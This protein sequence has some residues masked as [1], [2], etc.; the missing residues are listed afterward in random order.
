MN[1]SVFGKCMEDVRKRKDIRLCCSSKQAEKLIAKPNFKERTI[2]NS[3]LAAVHL[4][5]TEICFKK[6]ITVGMAVLDISK[7][8]MYKFYYEYM[9]PT[10]RQQFK[11]LYTDTDSFIFILNTNNV[12][13]DMKAEISR[14]DTS[15]YP[16][17]N[18]FDMPKMNKKKLGLMKDECNGSIM[19][20]FAGLRSK[21]YSFLVEGEA[22]T[23][24]LKGVK[25]H[26]LRRRITFEDYK[27]CITQ[28]TQTFT[29]MQ[30]IRSH[31]H[32]IFSSK[33]N[34]LSL[35]PHDEKRYI[36]EDGISTLAWGHHKIPS[37]PQ[38]QS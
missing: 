29:T 2:F 9:K 28:K 15:D 6:P 14:F 30:T 4:Q 5:K 19:T 20:E 16:S 32:D 12:Y 33:L 17:D 37:S 3:S 26:A 27:R 8:I 38:I 25:K 1:N 23:K 11:L 21:V 36:C 22:P 13:E 31:K 18:K 7:I 10:Y 34:K 35:S 24:K